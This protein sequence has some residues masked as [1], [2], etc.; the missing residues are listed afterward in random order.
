MPIMLFLFI[1]IVCIALS[2]VSGY[3]YGRYVEL[4]TGAKEAKHEV[5]PHGYEVVKPKRSRSRLDFGNQLDPVMPEGTLRAPIIE[6]KEV[7]DE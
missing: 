7:E 1:L 5:N 3:F 2:L 6:E 4:K